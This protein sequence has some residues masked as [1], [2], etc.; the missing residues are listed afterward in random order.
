MPEP[1]HATEPLGEETVTL[2]NA[3]LSGVPAVLM[4]TVMYTRDP[5]EYVD[6]SVT[7]ATVRDFTLDDGV[8]LASFDLL[9][10]PT[11]LTALT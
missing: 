5:R 4:V 7:T 2:T 10:S 3:P 1:V 11:E 8:A 9:D 6:L